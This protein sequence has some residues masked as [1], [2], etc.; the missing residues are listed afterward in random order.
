MGSGT[1]RFVGDGVLSAESV[2]V[3]GAVDFRE[4]GIDTAQLIVEKGASIDVTDLSG[5]SPCM[6]KIAG[7]G[8][9]GQGA[10]HGAS[11]TTR[12]VAG[13]TLMDDALVSVTGSWGV[14]PADESGDATLSLEGYTLT[15]A[16]AGEFFFEKAVNKSTAGLVE[17]MGGSFT[18]SDFVATTRVDI[19]VREGLSFTYRTS[20]ETEDAVT[21]A[22]EAYIVLEE[23]VTFCQET[24]VGI[25][26]THSPQLTFRYS[27]TNPNPIIATGSAWNVLSA[28]SIS[29]DVS[30]IR[31]M[32]LTAGQQLTLAKRRTNRGSFL[33]NG[34][35]LFSLSAIGSRYTAKTTDETLSLVV[36]GKIP[37]FTHYNF[38]D[39]YGR[40]SGAAPD[41]KYVADTYAYEWDQITTGS[42]V[43]ARSGQAVLLG[44]TGESKFAPSI[45]RFVSDGTY[46]NPF[47]NSGSVTVTT[48]MQPV[49][50]DRRIVWGL[51]GGDSVGVALVVLDETTLALVAEWQK[52]GVNSA[53]MLASITGIPKL[54]EDEHFVVA[55]ITGWG[56][57]LS[58]DMKP[59]LTVETTNTPPGT[60][61]S[62]TTLGYGHM[63]NALLNGSYL[64]A[65]P[66]EGCRL[67]DWRIYLAELSDEDLM[68]IRNRFWRSGF[69]LIV[70]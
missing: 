28:K 7:I 57:V 38:D 47:E 40:L 32:D 35:S 14:A 8:V 26:D 24:T 65:Q 17:V 49:A 5:N 30:A 46:A 2:V 61:N 33:L 15:K 56:T 34:S 29:I 55:K 70:H 54:T 1:L 63:F 62:V 37:K 66:A 52:N 23:G 45:Y 64:Q 68:R 69:S 4:G 12:T 13:L 53:M 41:S 39:G 67:N 9:D 16:G 3:S 10:V 6:L 22:N 11:G 58:V 59:S 19:V 50:T 51:G 48:V 31:Q 60:P 44:R 43:P 42:L 18:V 20:A 27:R 21:H 36:E 25:K